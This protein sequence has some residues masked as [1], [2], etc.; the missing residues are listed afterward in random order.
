MRSEAFPSETRRNSRGCS[1]PLLFRCSGEVSAAQT[2]E[3]SSVC[4][5]R[6]NLK[7]KNSQVRRTN[8]KSPGPV[9]SATFTGPG[10]P[11][12]WGAFGRGALTAQKNSDKGNT[13]TFL[14]RGHAGEF[15][16]LPA[17]NNGGVCAG[18]ANDFCIFS[19]NQ[20]KRPEAAPGGGHP[21]LCHAACCTA[22][23]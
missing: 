2:S 1:V 6:L 14:S 7:K 18:A 16:S 5:R 15:L 20:R 12:Q 4:G 23:N 22:K 9:C 13:G 8:P 21:L 11:S 3:P 19:P 10:R 17:G